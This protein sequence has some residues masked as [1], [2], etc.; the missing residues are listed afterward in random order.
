M[1]T[2]TGETAGVLENRDEEGREIEPQSAP[3]SYLILRFSAKQMSYPFIAL[4]SFRADPSY[5]C[6]G[7]PL[8]GFPYPVCM[9]TATKV[10]EDTRN[11][12]RL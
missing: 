12:P 9:M 2:Q 10:S 1:R 11:F 4:V 5:L 8:C 3:V 7:Q 6:V